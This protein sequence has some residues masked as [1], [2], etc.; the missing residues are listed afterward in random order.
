MDFYRGLSIAGLIAA[1]ATG[2]A[3]F[4]A[5]ASLVPGD[6]GGKGE[7]WALAFFVIACAACIG[8][9]ILAA[10]GRRAS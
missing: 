1:C 4:G 10:K 6:S 3:Y 2:A 7:K 5:C 8:F 9:G